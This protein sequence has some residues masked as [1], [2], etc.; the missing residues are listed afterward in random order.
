[1][2]KI[3]IKK[4]VEIILTWL[5]WNF[6]WL[7]LCWVTPFFLEAEKSPDIRLSVSRTKKVCTSVYI[8]CDLHVTPIYFAGAWSLFCCTKGRV[9]NDLCN[10][11]LCSCI[12]VICYNENHYKE[13]TENNIILFTVLPRLHGCYFQK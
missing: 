4:I 10:G 3:K 13:L 12:V 11:C 8:A 5:S 1:M 9:F 6:P 7:L 2:F